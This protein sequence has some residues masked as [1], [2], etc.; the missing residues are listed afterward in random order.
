ALV[1]DSSAAGPAPPAVPPAPGARPL[2]G[3]VRG[4]EEAVALARALLA[5][6]WL[7]DDLAAV[8]AGFR[9]TAVTRSGRAWSGATRELSQTSS[10]GGER[11]LA[12]RNRRDRLVAQSEQAVQAERSAL[13]AVEAVAAAVGAADT[14]RDDADRAL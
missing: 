8:A 3:L 6:A 13:A 2:A 14:E 7:V 12:E 10:G 4:P 5:D 11:V 1:H 9:G